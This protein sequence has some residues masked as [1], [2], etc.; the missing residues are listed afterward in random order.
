MRTK[1]QKLFQVWIGG[2][3][4]KFIPLLPPLAALSFVD[5]EKKN[6]RGHG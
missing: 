3:S 6:V 2:A 5:L 4:L 1:A